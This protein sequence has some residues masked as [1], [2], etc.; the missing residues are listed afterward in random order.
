MAHITV[1]LSPHRLMGAINSRC[2]WHGR[3]HRCNFNCWDNGEIKTA[4]CGLHLQ[5]QSYNTHTHYHSISKCHG[6]EGMFYENKHTI[7]Q[8]IHKQS[9]TQSFH[10][11][12]YH[13]YQGMFYL[14]N[15][16]TIHQ[17]RSLWRMKL[18]H[19]ASC[20]RMPGSCNSVSGLLLPESRSRVCWGQKSLQAP[21]RHCWVSSNVDLAHHTPN[22]P[23]QTYTTTI[24]T[25]TTI[26]TTT[27]LP[28]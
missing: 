25:I 9:Y 28:W 11:K 24:N 18:H 15:M 19:T 20:G 17:K 27:P 4:F 3:N 22:L 1:D 16:Y 2:I 23:T 6:Q 14:Q 10:I 21:L 12:S 8:H 26:N 13:W 7:H 5:K